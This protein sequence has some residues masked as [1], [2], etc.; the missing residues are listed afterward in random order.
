MR[1]AFI[2]QKGVP[3]K[4]GGIEKHVEEL[5]ARLAK[6]GF[7][8][9]VY[10]RPHYAG[11]RKSSFNGVN[12]ISLPSLNTKHL[13]AI[14]HTLLASIHASFGNYDVIHYHGVGPSLLS[15][16]PRLLS[17]RA[18]VVATFHCNDRLHQKW[19]MV[20]KLAL[21]VGEWA[22]CAFPHQTITVSRT[23]Q[24]YCLKHFGRQ[25][26]YIPNSTA[27]RKYKATGILKKLGIE[28]GGY[29]LSVSR[30]VQ[31]KGIHTLI[32]AYN[33][34]ATHKKLVIVGDGAN[35]G[36]YVAKLKELAA[37]NPKIIFAGKLTGD[38]LA[39][40][41]ANAAVFVQPSE[42]EG[43]SIALLEA[44]GYGL[45]MVISDIAENIEPAG[46]CALEFRNRNR[47]DLALKLAFALS[48]RKHMAKL[49]KAARIRVLKEYDWR[50][51]AKQTGALYR[52]LSASGKSAAPVRIMKG[53]L[54]S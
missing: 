31:H 46:G 50:E 27:I 54:A 42:A 15:W 13:D 14:T 32:Q 3:A 10:S 34:T 49:A 4:Q 5:S 18:K 45:P 22:T 1:I 2:G 43:M 29:I 21:T 26:A 38:D 35:T 20:A 28:K 16:I 17:P 30:L 25:A 53:N 24:A 7:D 39:T 6:G 8:V 51:I 47:F 52:S 48:H 9:S 37:G 44:M 19:G 41:F 36:K 40:V 33:E 23:L 11:N 12:I